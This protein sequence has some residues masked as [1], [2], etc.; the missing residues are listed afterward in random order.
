[1][2][3]PVTNA[4]GSTVYLFEIAEDHP[5][6]WVAP[7]IVKANDD[8]VLGTVLDPRFDLRRAALFDSL[9]DVK[10][11]AIE[12][13][14]EALSIVATVKQFEPG[15]IDIELDQPAPA[16]SALLVSENYYPGWRAT[17]DGKPANVGRADMT[18]TGV[19]L[20]EGGRRISLRFSSQPYEKGRTTTQVALLIGVVAWLGGV[21]LGFRR[22][23]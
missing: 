16:G 2:V 20:P 4:Y 12:A 3:G 6:A 19:Q 9:S 14:P 7:V 5:D 22:R 21:V 13:L 1:V 8:A 23:G 18:L 10:G 11:E 15:S 17:V